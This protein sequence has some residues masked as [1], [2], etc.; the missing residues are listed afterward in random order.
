MSYLVSDIETALIPGGELQSF[1]LTHS[2]QAAA[3]T[4]DVRVFENL[5]AADPAVA[6]SARH[7][8]QVM[9]AV[10]QH[11]FILEP[12]ATLSF[13][14]R[15]ARKY[16]GRIDAITP[17]ERL[18]AIIHPEDLEGLLGAYRDA[19]A[20][21][22]PVEAEARVRSKNGQYRWFLHQLFPLCD[23]QGRVVRWCGTRI[24]IDE[25]KRSTE[26]A[27]RENLAL[28]EEIDTMSM[29]EEIVG[30]S[31]RLRAVLARV[32]KVARTDSTVLIT[33]ETGTG[34]ELIARA[35]H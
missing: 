7:I 18:G 23:E 24:D 11:M 14:N 8:E 10:P 35:I 16:L 9:D 20:H 29:F 28:R 17:T 33:G 32:T 34:K 19:I 15:A 26:E 4:L 1:G 6:I 5:I 13:V 12:D 22:I 2:D 25:H 30:S 21:G 31:S 3:P 27:Q